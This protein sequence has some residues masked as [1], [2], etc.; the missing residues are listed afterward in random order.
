VAGETHENESEVGKGQK[1]R[2]HGEGP[3]EPAR[4]DRDEETPLSYGASPAGSSG[5]VPNRN[6]R[7]FNRT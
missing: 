1:G 2:D 5:H 6:L 3:H 4:V 7:E